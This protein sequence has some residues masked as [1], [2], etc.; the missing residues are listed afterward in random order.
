M[1]RLHPECQVPPTDLPKG[2]IVRSDRTHFPGGKETGHPLNRSSAS[3]VVPDKQPERGP[4]NGVHR[5]D[6]GQKE[7]QSVGAGIRRMSRPVW[8]LGDGLEQLSY[9]ATSFSGQ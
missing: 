6:E 7:A 2:G 4:P 1:Y 9:A 8:N 5:G 3:D